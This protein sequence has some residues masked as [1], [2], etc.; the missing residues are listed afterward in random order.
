MCFDC[1]YSTD[2]DDHSSDC[3]CTYCERDKVQQR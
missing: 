2:P 3:E 1:R